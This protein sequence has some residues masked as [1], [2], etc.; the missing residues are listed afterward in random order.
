MEEK[1]RTRQGT[2]GRGTATTL[3]TPEQEACCRRGEARRG[4]HWAMIVPA[5]LRTAVRERVNQ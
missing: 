3:P 4:G 1:G 5:G 2:P